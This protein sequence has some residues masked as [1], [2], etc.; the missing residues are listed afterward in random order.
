[1]ILPSNLLAF[2][3]PENLRRSD[4][5]MRAGLVWVAVFLKSI[6]RRVFIRIPKV[7]HLRPMVSLEWDSQSGSSGGRAPT[8]HPGYA[9][10]PGPLHTMSR[11]AH[12]PTASPR[13]LA[14]CDDVDV[15]LPGLHQSLWPLSEQ[16]GQHSNSFPTH[17]Q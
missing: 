9:L 1:M 11:V 6:L 17:G 8:A 14:V 15:Q 16:R 7:K 3:D 12:S 4:G 2:I 10:A 5:V 13:N